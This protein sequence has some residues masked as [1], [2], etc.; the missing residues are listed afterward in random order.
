MK[1]ARED[2]NRIQDPAGLIPADEPV[3]LIR[4]QDKVGGY[5]VRDWANRAESAGAAPDIV[6]RARHHSLLMDAWPA[7]KTPDLAS[8]ATSAQDAKPLTIMVCTADYR[9]DHAADIAI[10]LEYRPGETVEQLVGRAQLG[11]NPHA[12]GELVEIR[13]AQETAA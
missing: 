6:Q 8:A 2:Y 13:L 3:F 9:G 1:H 7:K 11:R 12:R 10:A 5:A 4:G